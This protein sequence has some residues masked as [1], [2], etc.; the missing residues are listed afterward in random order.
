MLSNNQLMYVC[1]CVS[2][3]GVTGSIRLPSTLFCQGYPQ[4]LDVA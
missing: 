2:G 1:V 3:W 4:S